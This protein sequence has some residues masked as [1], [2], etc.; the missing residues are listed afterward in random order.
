AVIRETPK[1]PLTKKKE[2]VDV[3]RG[4]DEDDRN[5]KQVSSGE[6]S[7]QEKASDNDKTQSD[8]ENESNSENVTDESK[9]G[10]ESDHEENKEDDD[11]ENET[12]ITDK[13]KGDE[14]EG[15]DHTTNK[16]SSQPP[17][18]YEAAVTLTKFELKKIFIDKID[19][20]ESYLAAPEHRECY[21]GLKKSYDLDKTIFSTYG[22]VYSLKKSQKDKDEHPFVGSDQGLKRRK[23]SKDVEPTKEFKV[24]ESDMP[25]DHKENLGKD[26]K[27]PKEKA[28]SEKLNSENPEGDDYPL[29]LTKP[30]TLVKIGNPQKVLV[31]YFF[32]NDLKYLQGGISIMTYTTS[33]TKTKATQYDLPGIEDMV[34]NI[35][36]PVKVACDKHVLSDISHWREQRKT[37]Y[38][39]V[40]GL[41]SKHDVYSMKRILAVTL[42]EIMRKH[43]YGYW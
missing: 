9:S 22:K 5:N 8:N 36:S 34:P 23:T 2:K 4:N 17:S 29:D 24:V 21:E 35:W 38:G 25:H 6:D 12:K 18:S 37:F 42:I 26:D 32:N 10:S 33:L 27:E 15:M 28:L 14:D 13:A 1:M 19:K 39:C 40:R 7:D 20:S 41:Q 16:E 30:L 31:E 11:A 43:G 3:T